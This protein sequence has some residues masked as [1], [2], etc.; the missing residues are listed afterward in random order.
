M[1]VISVFDKPDVMKINIDDKIN[2]PLP[3]LVVLE[4]ASLSYVDRH[5]YSII[6]SEYG[7]RSSECN[8]ESVDLMAVDL[9]V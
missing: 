8:T 6:P 7:K 3:Y 4:R 9:D 2:I 1:L 5:T